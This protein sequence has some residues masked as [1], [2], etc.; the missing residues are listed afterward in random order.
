MNKMMTQGKI[1]PDPKTKKIDMIEI[2][3]EIL[4]D[5]ILANA[6]V[7]TSVVASPLAINKCLRNVYTSS[8]I[9]G[10]T[11]VKDYCE[12]ILSA[13]TGVGEWLAFLANSDNADLLA[14]DTIAQVNNSSSGRA[15][16]LGSSQSHL[17]CNNGLNDCIWWTFAI[18][19]GFRRTKADANH[20]N[21]IY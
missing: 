4:V 5:L 6:E 8:R 21:V 7:L 16:V 12:S 9:T 11:Q 1:K 10:E 14:C 18:R 3:R 2:A 20:I 15:V 17:E 13:S 19:Y